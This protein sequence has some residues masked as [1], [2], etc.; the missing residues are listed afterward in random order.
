[1]RGRGHLRKVPP[2]VSGLQGS[3]SSSSS[4]SSSLTPILA[5]VVILAVGS[6]VHVYWE[7]NLLPLMRPAEVHELRAVV[8]ADTGHLS[9][10][11]YE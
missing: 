8:P 4:E 7:V 6:L 10:Q 1:M 11:A 9:A 5:P 3:C 2:L